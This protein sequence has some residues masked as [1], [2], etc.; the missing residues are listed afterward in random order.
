MRIEARLEE[1]GLALPESAKPPPGIELSFAWIRVRGDRTSVSGHGPLKPDGSIAQPFGKVGVDL[2]PEQGYEAARL[3]ALS[4]LGG[5]KR[6]L[7]DL[8][9]VSAW[10]MVYGLVNAAAG[11]R[12]DDQRDNRLLGL[13]SGSLRHRS[14]GA[15]PRGAGVAT[16]PLGLP[17]SIAAEVEIGT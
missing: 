14:R 9:R 11:L 12:G 1:R 5:L 2:S 17:V 4:V 15:R 13:D 16:P 3:T 6:E 7:D 8:D 10:L